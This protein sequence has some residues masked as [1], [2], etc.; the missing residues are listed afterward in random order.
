MKA[1]V[2][3]ITGASRGIG[4]AITQKFVQAGYQVFGTTR[5]ASPVGTED[6]VLRLDV[7]DDE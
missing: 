4:K 3:L 5:Q 2:V 7:Q 1:P 6:R